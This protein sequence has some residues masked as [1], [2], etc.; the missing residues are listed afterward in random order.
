MHSAT[1]R[2]H[3]VTLEDFTAWNPTRVGNDSSLGD[4]TGHQG[5]MEAIKNNPQSRPHWLINRDKQ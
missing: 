2:R 4:Q 1:M 3:K 5:Y